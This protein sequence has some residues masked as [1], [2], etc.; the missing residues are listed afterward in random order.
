MKRLLVLQHLER[1]GPGIFKDVANEFHIDVHIVRTDM[2]HEIPSIKDYQGLLVLGGPMGISDIG[3]PKFDFL[4][5]E[6]HIIKE[7]QS[8]HIPIIGVCL[9]AQLISHVSGG[10]IQ[11]LLDQD[12]QKPLAEI[13]WSPIYLNKKAHISTFIEHLSLPLHVLHWH[14]DRICLPSSASLIASS[15]R[16][17][18]QFFQIGSNSIGLQFHVEIEYQDIMRWID[19]DIDFIMS[20]LGSDAKK[21]LVNQLDEF[22]EQTRHN[23]F[24]LIRNIF[25]YL[26]TDYTD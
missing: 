7:A 12:S 21:I 8:K 10:S 11:K 2:S 6:I 15:D 17:K 20:A 19:E 13:G 1:E 5:Q 4:T 25:R 16:C 9:G 3:N 18:E 24:Q 14:E 23:R 22:C 26:W